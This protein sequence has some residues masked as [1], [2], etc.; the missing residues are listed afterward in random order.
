MV[1]M[2]LF[3][4]YLDQ[5]FCSLLLST[6]NVEWMTFDLSQVFLEAPRVAVTPGGS[7]LLGLFFC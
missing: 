4:L 1:E 6:A 2:I 7:S 3:T 5:Y